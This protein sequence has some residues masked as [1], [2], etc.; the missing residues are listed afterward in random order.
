MKYHILKH[1][2]SAFLTQPYFHFH[3]FVSLTRWWC[4]P[5]LFFPNKKKLEEES[6]IGTKVSISAVTLCMNSTPSTL[7][8]QSASHFPPQVF[9][10]KQYKFLAHSSPH[11]KKKK[12]LPILFITL[13]REVIE[14]SSFWEHT[15]TICSQHLVYSHQF[16][17]LHQT[18]NICPSFLLRLQFDRFVYPSVFHANFYI[19]YFTE[20]S[21]TKWVCKNTVT[22]EKTCL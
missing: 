18:S 4:R 19:S 5:C 7:I 22:A 14:N 17:I 13:G 1:W 11:L 2:A 10:C 21:F 9:A 6:A 8:S 15:N 12:S 16:G 3:S 20:S